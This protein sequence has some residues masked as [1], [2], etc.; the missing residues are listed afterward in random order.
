MAVLVLVEAKAKPDMVESIKDFVTPLFPE[1]RAYDGC[2]GVTMYVEPEG[3]TFVFVEH[4]DS[5][6]QYERYLAWRTETGVLDQLVSMLDGEPSIR[7][8][9]A[10]DA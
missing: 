7:Y 2:Q 5:T 4:W 6:A 1:T 9:E 8:F 10:V 3:Q